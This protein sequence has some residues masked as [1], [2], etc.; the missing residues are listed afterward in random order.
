[1]PPDTGVPP[2]QHWPS[3]PKPAAAQPTESRTLTGAGITA[4]PTG[5]PLTPP[6]LPGYEIEGEIGR[7]GMGV[8][9]RA[10]HRRLNRTVALKMIL[11]GAHA[12]ADQVVRFLGEAEAVAKLHHPNI[13]QI[14]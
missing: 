1:M 8:V 14:Y 11:A 4:A 3:A 9:Y 2:T 5:G 7:G 6:S 10:Q 12:G 13:V